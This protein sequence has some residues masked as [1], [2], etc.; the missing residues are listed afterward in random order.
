MSNVQPKQLVDRQLLDK[1]RTIL[2]WQGD[3]KIVP[4][5]S[6]AP[7]LGAGPCADYAPSKSAMSSP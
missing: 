1:L 3:E 6:A 4:G 2:L 7:G 5:R